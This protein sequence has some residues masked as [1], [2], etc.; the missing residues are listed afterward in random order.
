MRFA[1]EHQNPLVVGSAIGG[2]HYPPDSYWLVSS[3]DPGV[4]LW[5]LKPSE[6]GIDEG[7]IARYWN[8]RSAERSIQITLNAPLAGARA[9]TH[10][11]TDLASLPVSGNAVTARFA[12]QQIR[13]FR[14][15]RA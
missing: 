9:V 1:L 5:A 6:E 13:T 8:V 7:V 3:S 15:R 2:G 14:L 11:E 10:L 12:P 4:L